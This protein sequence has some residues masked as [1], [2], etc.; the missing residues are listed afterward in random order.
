MQRLTGD[1]RAVMELFRAFLHGME[2]RKPASL[3]EMILP[4]GVMTRVT[5]GEV[6]QITLAALLDTVFPNQGTSSLEERIYDPLVRT[7]GDI[8]VIWCAY[9]FRVDGK[10]TH[11]GTNI[12]NLARV[13]G[14]WRI[15]GLSDTAR[16]PA[17]A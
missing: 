9:D 13:D 15:S 12:I 1:E 3:R 14:R 11:S 16:P 7:D 10:I 2:Q 4:S 5:Q 6:K 8:A 17:A